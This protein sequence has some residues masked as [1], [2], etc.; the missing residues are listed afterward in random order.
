MN[1]NVT[2]DWKFVLALGGSV[3]GVILATKA[4]SDGAERVLAKT[5]DACKEGVV[6]VNSNH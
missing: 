2:I 5:V 4:D 6:A 1:L 3:A